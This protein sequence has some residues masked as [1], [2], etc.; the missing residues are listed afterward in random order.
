L[1]VGG[2]VQEASTII[3]ETQTV[4]DNG[5]IL[6]GVSQR[7]VDVVLDRF[8]VPSFSSAQ[9]TS[10][11][12]SRLN[13]IITTPSKPEGIIADFLDKAYKAIEPTK[14]DIGY[15][16][17]N[18]GTAIYYLNRYLADP[19]A[20]LADPAQ[21]ANDPLHLQQYANDPA[22]LAADIINPNGNATWAISALIAKQ[23]FNDFNARYGT[24]FT[25]ASE[26][27]QAAL[28]ATFFKQGEYTVLNKPG[29]FDG[30]NAGGG[31]GGQMVLDNFGTIRNIV[32]ANA[33]D[34]RTP[35]EVIAADFSELDAVNT[36][37]KGGSVSEV[38]NST[39]T[40]SWS[41]QINVFDL[42]DVLEFQDQVQRAGGNL[43]KFYD[44]QNTHLYNEL[45]VA[46]APD[47]KVT[48]AQ[49]V[50]DQR[51]INAGGSIGQIFGSAL[52]S[53]LGGKDQLTK[54]A[55][56]V[57]GG[58]I[59]S[60]IGHQFGLVVATSMAADLSKVSLTDVFALQNIDIASAG[61]GAVSSFLTAELGNALQIPGF[62]GQLFNAA[63]NGFTLSVLSQVKTGIGAGLTFDGAIAAIDWSAAVSGAIDATGLNIGNL[64]GTFLGQLLVPAKSHE[65][66]IGGQLLGAIGSFLLPGVGSLIGTILGTVIGD[67][68]GN[69]PHP[70]ATDLLDQAGDHYASTH[71]QT[72]ASDGGSYG[73]PDQM[74][75]PALAIINGYLSAVK[76]AALDH[77]KQVTIGYQTD[78]SS[79]YIVG[80]PGHPAAA[81]FFMPGFAVQAAAVDLLQ[82]TEA[83][84]GD[85]LLKRAHH[86]S[87]FYNPPPMPPADPSGDPGPTGAPLQPIA[88][89]QLA[90]LSGDL[91]VAQD[92]E[93]YL[94]NREA[95]NALMAANPESAFT[96]GWIATFARVS[97]LGL[98]HANA[99]DF[100]GGLV[101]YLDSVN[102]AG[103]GF[104]AASVSVKQGGGGSVAVEIK[105]PNGTDVPGS[106]SVFA[107]QTNEIS[108]VT[109]T[110]VQLVFN[111]ALAAGGFHGPASAALVSGTWQ[112]TGA[113][114]NNIW[115]GRNDMPNHFDASA[116]ANAILVGGALDDVLSGSNGWDFLDGGAGNDTLFGGG[117]N[118]ILRGGRGNDALVGGG[119]ND[120][121]GFARGDGFDVVFDDGGADTL[122]FG[123]GISLSDLVVGVDGADL[124][125]G[126]KDP[127]HPNTPFGQLTD[128]LTLQRWMDADGK[129]RIETFAFADGAVLNVAAGMAAFAPYLVPFG[130]TLSR[131]SVA[132]NSAIGTVVG[133]V[134]GFD[135]ATTNLSYSLVN[136]DGPFAINASTGV[137][138]V[139]NGALLDY[140]DARSHPIVARAADQNGHVFAK[141]FTIDVTNVNEAP[142]NATLAGGAVAENSANGTVVATVAGLDPDAGATLRY[143][144]TDNA[145]RR[146]QDR[147]PKRSRRAKARKPVRASGWRR[148]RGASASMTCIQKRFA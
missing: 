64:L 122:E 27:Q 48:G 78:P 22:K 83:I 146:S 60:L 127:A 52:G 135:L 14:N 144:L 10:D 7:V 71:Y 107:D 11:Y 143:S 18:L 147:S 86:N 117:G 102:K 115:F 94:N 128:I 130:E 49:V 43:I 148:A 53:A 46:K 16:N 106:L 3:T 124:I 37:G 98:N 20:Y 45:D 88:T 119:G 123:L 108:D 116:S 21:A 109:G 23:G 67:L 103:L 100:L 75:D 57:V 134:T 13:D 105:V 15:A 142:I 66:A 58:T 59:G 125:V 101:G 1:I 139:A 47:G 92:Y 39:G 40:E 145:A 61:I 126:V 42:N 54:L 141:T 4:I 138:T 30:T 41:S 6:T 62:G 44:T 50:L 114:G 25:T 91:G 131:N 56:S 32:N 111:N 29:I 5:Q 33:T 38:K 96:A 65:G 129:D 9:I 70:A 68:F 2:A 24:T 137:V 77:S 35:A 97:E 26:D 104:D 93:N 113:S 19:S 69:T 82:H 87:S 110:T 121:Y 74:A 118:D 31:S 36:A 34:P 55:S 95:I 136:A 12:A 80:V 28:L 120:T 72:S 90:I 81:V 73:V 8:I 84:G 79:S 132:E 140:E 99:S 85:L 51:V 17:I 133:T 89:T 76:G 63:A 112:V